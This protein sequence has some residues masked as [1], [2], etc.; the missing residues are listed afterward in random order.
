MLSILATPDMHAHNTFEEPEAVMP[1]RTAWK[2]APMLTLPKASVV[3]LGAG[4]G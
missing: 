1:V 3:T 2:A 4:I